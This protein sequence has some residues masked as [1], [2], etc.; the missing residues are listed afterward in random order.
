MRWHDNSKRT[1]WLFVYLLGI[2]IIFI[3]PMLTV[4]LLAIISH[5]VLNTSLFASLAIGAI[6]VGVWNLVKISY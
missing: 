1:D 4:C 6:S 3:I 2:A 5:F